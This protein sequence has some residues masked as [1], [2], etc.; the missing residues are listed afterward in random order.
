MINLSYSGASCLQECE[1][2]FELRYIAKVEPDRDV[3]RPDYFS[4]GEAFHKVCEVTKHDISKIK[5]INFDG[6]VNA[7]KLDP[8]S[9]GGR[10]LGML[11]A[12]QVLH[13]SVGLDCIACEIQFRSD[14]ANG[15]IDAVMVEKEYTY[16]HKKKNILWGKPGAWWIVD[17]KTAGQMIGNLPARIVNDPQ[18]N[19]YAAYKQ[20]I[21][22]KLGLDIE[23][24]A[25]VRYR[26]A[27]KPRLKFNGDFD[28]YVK[29]NFLATTVR[30][31][32][33]AK[34]EMSIELNYQEFQE[35]VRRANNLLERFNAEKKLCGKKNFKNCL[36][37]GNPCEYFSWCYGKTFTE[38]LQANRVITVS[39]GGCIQDINIE[40][41]MKEFL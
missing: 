29:K 41:E 1:R 15:I 12:Y 34:H 6:I 39:D 3:E 32:V 33:V 7:C 22:D 31:I 23:L 36:N 37:Y 30:E 8:L 25:G 9:D 17:L 16:S 5:T 14:E 21:A 11:Q 26:E 27:I 13:E 24:F 4:F 18:L 35:S 2:K 20:F 40:D 19:V 38:S 10:L 28:S